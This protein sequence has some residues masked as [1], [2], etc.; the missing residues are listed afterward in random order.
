MGL[1]RLDSL[2]KSDCGYVKLLSLR[3]RRKTILE[4]NIGPDTLVS[5]SV[6]RRLFLKKGLLVAAEN[7]ARS[8]RI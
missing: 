2:S 5:N 1:G 3:K 6:I 7:S 8:F 4:I